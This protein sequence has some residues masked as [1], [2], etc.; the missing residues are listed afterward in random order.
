MFKPTLIIAELLS[1]FALCY[2]FVMSAL[3]SQPGLIV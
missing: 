2:I 1:Y 3:N